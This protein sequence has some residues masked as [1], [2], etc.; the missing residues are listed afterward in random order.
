MMVHCFIA[1]TLAAG[2]LVVASYPHLHSLW[3]E[4]RRRVH[5]QR[6]LR[7]IKAL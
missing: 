1:I 4:Y 7:M 6:R 3:V 2:A 5:W